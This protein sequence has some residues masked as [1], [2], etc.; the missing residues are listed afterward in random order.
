M[1][2]LI[3]VKKFTRYRSGFRHCRRTKATK[4]MAIMVMVKVNTFVLLR[5]FERANLTKSKTR[6]YIKPVSSVIYINTYV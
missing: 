3:V 5:A 6:I 1:V 4:V 2:A